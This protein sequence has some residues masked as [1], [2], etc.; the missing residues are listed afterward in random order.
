MAVLALGVV[1][2]ALGS[3]IGIGASAGWL[4]VHRI[5][6][7]SYNFYWSWPLFIASTGLSWAIFWMME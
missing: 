2:S 6:I 4:D 1:G 3:A 5:T 7:E